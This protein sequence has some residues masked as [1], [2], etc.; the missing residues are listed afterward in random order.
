MNAADFQKMRHNPF[1]CKTGER[2]WNKYPELRRYES[3]STIPDISTPEGINVVQPDEEDVDLMVKFVILFVDRH[4]NPLGDIRDFDYRRDMALQALGIK[5]RATGIW[6]FIDAG[7]RWY[8]NVMFDY[9]KLV[10]DDQYNLWFSLK[11]SYN[12]NMKML[13]REFD[14]AT[15]DKD[16]KVIQQ[17]KAQ[18]PGDLKTLQEIEM[19][20]F[21]DERMRDVIT[22]EAMATDRHAERYAAD[23]LIHGLN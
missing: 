6:Y 18:A 3:L 21:A 12:V 16:I 10:N 19:K 4:G 20:L 15:D 8:Q 1:A 23:E 5:K 9:F 13:R 17:I 14:S 11:V 7:H 2:I 22:K